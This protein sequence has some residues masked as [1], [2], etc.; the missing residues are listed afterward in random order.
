MIDKQYNKRSKLIDKIPL[1]SNKILTSNIID[2][3]KATT[4]NRNLNPDLITISNESQY[5]TIDINKKIKLFNDFI[6]E[7]NVSSDIAIKN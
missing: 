3:E 1:I 5:V 6:R 2:L 4:N 7:T